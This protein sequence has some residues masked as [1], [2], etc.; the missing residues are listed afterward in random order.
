M[1]FWGSDNK[2]LQQTMIHKKLVDHLICVWSANES[3]FHNLHKPRII[4]GRE[5][6]NLPPRPYH[7]SSFN[8][9][10]LSLYCEVQHD[11]KTLPK[12]QRTRGLSSSFQSNFLKSYQVLLHKSCSNFIFRILLDQ[13]WTLNSQPRHYNSP[14]IPY[15]AIQSSPLKFSLLNRDRT[16]ASTPSTCIE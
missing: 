13:E 2:T 7:F 1:F 10:L 6:Y 14:L 15:S 16:S 8:L 12:A 4:S 3:Y 5:P 11:S 9:W